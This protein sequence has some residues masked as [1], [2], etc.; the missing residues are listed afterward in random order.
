MYNAI[1]IL[2][3]DIWQIDICLGQY[4]SKERAEHIANEGSSGFVF[5]M[6][7]E[8]GSIMAR[9]D[10]EVKFF[11]DNDVKISEISEEKQ[12]I[13]GK[14]LDMSVEGNIHKAIEALE[15]NDPAYVVKEEDMVPSNKVLLDFVERYGL[16]YKPDHI[17]Y[18][19]E[20]A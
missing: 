4:E 10:G 11:G 12:K 5:I 1:A 17:A 18:G 6:K 19:T 13:M 16:G 14:P 9:V 8:S 15:N 3:E 20:V 2:G 7:G